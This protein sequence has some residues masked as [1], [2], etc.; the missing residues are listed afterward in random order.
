[1][2]PTLQLVNNICAS[3]IN[4]GKSGED[5]IKY[6]LNFIV[7][8]LSNDKRLQ[9]KV[10]Y[11][12]GK[13]IRSGFMIITSDRN[14]NMSNYIT[15]RTN[16]VVLKYDVDTNA[17][18][19][20]TV[21]AC[22]PPLLSNKFNSNLSKFLSSY[23]IYPVN[24][25]TIV[26]LYYNGKKWCVATTHGIDNSNIKWQD[27]TYLHA[28]QES[29]YHNESTV[30]T[31]VASTGT[32]ASTEA[33]GGVG[34]VGVVDSNDF[35][36]TVVESWLAHLKTLNTKMSY[37]IRFKHPMY[38]TYNPSYEFEVIMTYLD[39]KMTFHG[40]PLH[41][42]YA[43]ICANTNNAL[44]N[45]S[46]K[47]VCYGYVL[48]SNDGTHPDYL[49][50]S[51]LMKTIRKMFYNVKTPY[52]KSPSTTSASSMTATNVASVIVYDKDGATVNVPL[53]SSSLRIKYI[54][55]N[56]YL[57]RASSDLFIKLF[58]QYT[59]LYEQFEKLINTF[60]ER[61]VFGTVEDHL[62]PFIDAFRKHIEPKCEVS[63][64]NEKIIYD[65]L[66]DPKYINQF[67]S[68]I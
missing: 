17:D 8:K 60:I 62:T 61:I 53:N 22:P 6:K 28:L 14:A 2:N 41:I 48:R 12:I 23:S 56:A 42:D 45:A 16:G 9:P 1:M 30:P 64:T 19:K 20:F 68:M 36:D 25:G 3:F 24:D 33:V 43:T 15:R 39:D 55:M 54:V 10:S 46:P 51:N 44:A 50:E 57:N 34:P 11:T 47:D 58:S 35:V 63:K 66:R 27:M 29:F 40:T 65:L 37:T 21:L 26:T 52:D 67:F 32:V 18:F 31:K 5:L 4:Y 59:N 49:I 13:T 7:N 38:H